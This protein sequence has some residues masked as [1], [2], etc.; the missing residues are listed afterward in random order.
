MYVIK[1]Y[2][3]LEKCR[4]PFYPHL[5]LIIL[6]RCCLLALQKT[7]RSLVHRSKQLLLFALVL[8]VKLTGNMNWKMTPGTIYQRLSN[9]VPSCNNLAHL[10]N[11]L[12]RF[13]LIHSESTRTIMVDMF[14]IWKLHYFRSDKDSWKTQ[15]WLFHCRAMLSSSGPFFS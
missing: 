9:K 12:V 1:I 3:Y 7:H 13:L 15:L 11:M 4:L 14:I 2:G 6:Q 8:I 5:L 10:A